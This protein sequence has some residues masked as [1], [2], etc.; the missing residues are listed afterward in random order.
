MLVNIM[1]ALG[2]TGGGARQADKTYNGSMF[3]HLRLHTEFSVVDSTNR[4]DEGVQSAATGG[5]PTGDLTAAAAPR[6]LVGSFA[7]SFC[8]PRS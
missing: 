3:V 2:F 5:L 7:M 4:I 1:G 8:E 6:K